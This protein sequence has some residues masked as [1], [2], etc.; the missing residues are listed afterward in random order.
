M[1]FA[2]SVISIVACSLALSAAADFLSDAEPQM[3]HYQGS[4]YATWEKLYAERVQVRT[5]RQPLNGQQDAIVRRYLQ[6]I[7]HRVY[8]N[9]QTFPLVIL[10]PGGNSSAEQ[11]RFFDMSDRFERLAD[12]ENFMLVYA[13]AYALDGQPAPHVAEQPFNANQGYWRTCVGG[14]GAGDN[15]YDV[16]DT[17]Y[18]KAVIAQMQREALPIDPDRIYIVGLSNGGEMAEHVARTMGDQIAAVAAVNPVFGLPATLE[19]NTCTAEATQAPLSMMIMHSTPDPILTPIFESLGID[20]KAFTDQSVAAWMGAL[21]VNPE[22]AVE[23]DLPNTVFEGED[24]T[25]DEHWSLATRNSFITRTNYSPAANGATF[26]RLQVH[27][28]GHQWPTHKAAPNDDTST[29]GFR[30]QDINA[31]VVIWDFLKDKLRIAE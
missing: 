30:N 18:I 31:E 17:A 4:P 10:L 21:G 22:S 8:Q 28:G 19:L 12:A 24:Y 3:G 23:Y 14:P 6:Y 13:N 1:L 9:D 29:F 27:G 5:F 15:F 26:T 2:R 11:L 25:G 20:Y 16:D 7:P